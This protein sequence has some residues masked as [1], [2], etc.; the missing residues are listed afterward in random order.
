[1]GA[2]S[3][4]EADRELRRKLRGVTF[5][6]EVRGKSPLDYVHYICVPILRSELSQIR[7]RM[8]EVLNFA[9]DLLA[10]CVFFYFDRGR[11]IGINYSLSSSVNSFSVPARDF[12]LIVHEGLLESV[13]S[14]KKKLK[15]VPAHDDSAKLYSY[16]HN[17]LLPPDAYC[18]DVDCFDGKT[19]WELK[20]KDESLS[21]NQKVLSRL[22]TETPYNFKVVHLT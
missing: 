20:R 1:M 2:K 8:R 12:L 13:P 4:K 22:L 3:L 11:V 5:F 15:I 21:Y 18:V 14:V 17:R 9:R 6:V 19:V 10:P 16:Y 7:Y